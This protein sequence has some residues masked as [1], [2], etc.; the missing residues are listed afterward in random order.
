M[1]RWPFGAQAAQRCM[2]TPQLQISSRGVPAW[3]TNPQNG[4]EGPVY[5]T[6]DGA[7]EALVL[8]TSESNVVLQNVQH[9]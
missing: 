6:S 3:Q 8:M 7:C 4:S 5:G 2:Q 1:F 9:L